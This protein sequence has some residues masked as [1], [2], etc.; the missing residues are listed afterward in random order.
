MIREFARELKACIESEIER[1]TGVTGRGGAKNFEEYR[2][3]VGIYVGLKRAIDY[4]DEISRQ[5]D[6]KEE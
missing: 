4:V 5:Y 1:E 2:H 3:R 6:E